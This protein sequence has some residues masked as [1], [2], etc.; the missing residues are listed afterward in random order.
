MPIPLLGA[1]LGV[2]GTAVRLGGAALG[3]LA[4]APGAK[5]VVGAA[6]YAARRTPVFNKKGTKIVGYRGPRERFQEA[7]FYDSLIDTVDK[8]FPSQTRMV[9]VHVKSSV[10][11]RLSTA[12][13]FALS[14]AFGTVS[15]TVKSSDCAI[16]CMI[17]HTG[18]AV[19]IKLSYQ[20]SGPLGNLQS[21]F[22]SDSGAALI[23]T[24][25]PDSISGAGFP[26]FLQGSKTSLTLGAFGSFD[27]VEYEKLNEQ[28][29]LVKISGY[30]LPGQNGK[31][32]II[33]DEA[34]YAYRPFED[35]VMADKDL[36]SMFSQALVEEFPPSH[37]EPSPTDIYSNVFPGGFTYQSRFSQY[38]LTPEPMSG[39]KI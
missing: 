7:W 33:S 20:Y 38:Y 9:E 10:S 22:S 11:G 16:D 4:K 17:D 31:K 23:R 27:E 30:E 1:A 14:L 25:P 18:K 21:L 36:I 2:A 3:A 15:R 39:V 28:G 19:T 13:L 26:P 5:Q 6:R 35:S 12:Y 29:G 24:P 34:D 8:S 37:P 32:P